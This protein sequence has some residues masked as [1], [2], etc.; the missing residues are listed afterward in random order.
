MSRD[1][2]YMEYKQWKEP[3]YLQNGYKLVSLYPNDLKNL[4]D[5]LALAISKIK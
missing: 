3:L 5:R 1:P 2:A 4:R